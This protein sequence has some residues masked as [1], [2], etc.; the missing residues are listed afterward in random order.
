[1]TRFKTIYIFRYVS[2]LGSC[3]ALYTPILHYIY[4]YIYILYIHT[5]I[6]IYIIYI[7]NAVMITTKSINVGQIVEGVSLDLESIHFLI[8]NF[9]YTF[10]TFQHHFLTTVLNTFL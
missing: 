9:I 5:Y 10:V 4:I 6:Y 7:F 2:V 1:M 8:I 3:N